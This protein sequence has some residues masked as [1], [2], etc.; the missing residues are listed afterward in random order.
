[1]SLVRGYDTTTL[2][3]RSLTLRSLMV[4]RRLR[5]VR[6]EF[7]F[8]EVALAMETRLALGASRIGQPR[9]STRR[10]TR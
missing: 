1:V 2:T 4:A 10:I 3:P 8:D 7:E 6:R 9:E 5:I